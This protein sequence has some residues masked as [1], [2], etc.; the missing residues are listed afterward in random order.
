MDMT[1]RWFGKKFDSVTLEQI[2]QI[3]GVTGVITTLYDTKPGEVWETEKIRAIK[4]EIEDAGLQLKGI[5]SVNIHDAIK[6]GTPDREQY[7]DNYITTLE[8]LGQEGVDL[9]CYNFM[10]VFD[11]T[12]SDLA[13][14]RPDGSTVLSYDQELIDAIDPEKMMDSMDEK[15]NGFEL[16]GWEPERMAKIK[17]L[18]ELYKDVDEEKLFAN[19]KYFLE[20]IMPTCEKY[21][22]KMAIH[23]DDPSWSVFGLSRIMTSK[24]NL[25]KLVTMVDSPCN[26]VTLCTGSLGSNPEND[27]PDI[28]RSLKGK[29]HFGHIRNIV[30]LG[31]KKFDE[32][33]HLSSDGSLD[34]YEIMKAL[35][36]IG[37]DGVIRPDHGRAIW[38]EVSM[39][40]YGLY[41]RALGATYLNGLWESIVKSSK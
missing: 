1:L 26:G 8:R 12:R 2:R 20:R 11:W 21:G 6:V 19:L 3:P 39:P 17:E 16:P 18:F 35:Y 28:I 29:I 32:A 4:K 10:P 13:K 24:E 38:G 41:D 5:E 25:L 22:I 30:H 37:F 15:S 40:G 27:I 34:M 33:A 14:V 23:P 9:V 31:P 7:I 36:E